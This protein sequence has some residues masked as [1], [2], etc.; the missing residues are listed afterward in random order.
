MSDTITDYIRGDLRERILG[1]RCS[2]SELT[3]TALSE[4]YRVSL[5]PVRLA[6]RDLIAEKVLVKRP[7]GRLGMNGDESS[8]G[9]E[10][11]ALQPLPI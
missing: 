6:V 8:S 5:T 9:D 4:R 3:L 11:D 2:L 10:S 7:N 1:Q